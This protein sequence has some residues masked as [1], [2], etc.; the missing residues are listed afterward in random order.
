[1]NI[2]TI[3]L[4]LDLILFTTIIIIIYQR[5]RG[6]K[7][8]KEISKRDI[9]RQKAL[10]DFIKEREERNKIIDEFIEKA[11]KSAYEISKNL[12]QLS[13]QKELLINRLKDFGVT[14]FSF[15]NTESDKV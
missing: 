7:I 3:N 11:N 1:M 12:I 4:I 6:N 2:F 10:D 14:D 5:R 9:E 15:L 8:I 13:Q